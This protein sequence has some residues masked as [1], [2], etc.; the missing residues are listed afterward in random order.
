MVQQAT[1]AF[2]PTT[3]SYPS[4]VGSVVVVLGLIISLLL[5]TQA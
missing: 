4:L 3:A 2:R 5:V 1:T